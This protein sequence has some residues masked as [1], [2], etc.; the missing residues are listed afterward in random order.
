[1]NE[2]GTHVINGALPYRPDA[3]ILRILIIEGSYSGEDPDMV[4]DWNSS[5]F[6]AYSSA[7]RQHAGENL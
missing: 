1:M 4:S 2:R 5:L 3:S 7:S 6:F